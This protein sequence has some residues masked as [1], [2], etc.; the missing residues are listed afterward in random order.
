MPVSKKKRITPKSGPSTSEP[1]SPMLP[2]QQEFY[3]HSG[4]CIR[5]CQ[6]HRGTVQRL[7]LSPDGKWLASCGDDGAIHLW[8]FEGGDLLRTLQ[9]DRPYER[10]EI[11]GAKG[12]TQAQRASLRMLGATESAPVPG[13]QDAS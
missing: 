4:E 6:A 2:Q 10:L 13:I 3:R 1:S 12:L 8:D 5:V 9:R 11:N 7:R